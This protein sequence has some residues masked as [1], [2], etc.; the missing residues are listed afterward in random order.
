MFNTRIHINPN[1]PLR[2]LKSMWDEDERLK[3]SE[4]FELMQ[5]VEGPFAPR[6]LGSGASQALRSIVKNPP[7]EGVHS[8]C[9]PAFKWCAPQDPTAVTQDGRSVPP[10]SA[11]TPLC[12]L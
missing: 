2:I 6:A 1:G 4:I 11:A 5:N 3:E 12:T 9:V 10:R 8:G 7:S